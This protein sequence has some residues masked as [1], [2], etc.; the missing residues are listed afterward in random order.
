[1]DDGLRCIGDWKHSSIRFHLELDP[2]LL[3]PR[4][5]V[6]RLKSLQ[7]ADQF[8]FATRIAA[9]EFARL[10]KRMRDVAT[11]PARDADLLQ[12]LRSLF[13]DNSYRLGVFRR[14]S[15]RR[16]KSRQPAANQF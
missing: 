13:H 4:N 1:V 2:A 10:K 8:A 12:K 16:K 7:Q 11:A 15:D 14:Q 3:K 6:A 5:G 9:R